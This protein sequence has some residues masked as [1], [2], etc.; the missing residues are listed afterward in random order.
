[1]LLLVGTAVD[2]TVDGP[3]VLVTCVELDEVV[4]V[5]GEVTLETAVAGADEVATS[6]VDDVLERDFVDKM[7]ELVAVLSPSLR[8]DIATRVTMRIASITIIIVNVLEI[9]T[10]FLG[11]L[12]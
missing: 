12:E 6:V 2:E 8:L 9:A 7:L 4:A 11:P 10:R 3:V 5:D 1:M